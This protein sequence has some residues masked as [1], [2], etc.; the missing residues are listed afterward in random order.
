M[1][2]EMGSQQFINVEIPL[3]W[4][5]RAVIQDQEGHI[6]V[7]DLSGDAARLEIV[8]DKP[9]PG[10]EFVP[11]LDGFEILLN[12]EAIYSY[13]PTEKKLISITL[14]LPDCQISPA[15]TRIGTNVFSMNIV[16][17]FPVGI[18]VSEK[19]IA[20]GAPIPPGLAKLIVK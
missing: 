3:L 10:V 9:A 7:I 5:T 1:N 6:S 8:G 17:G 16:A 4:G 2:I 14:R 18:A 13:N 15:E 19:G 20:L 11:T 12:G